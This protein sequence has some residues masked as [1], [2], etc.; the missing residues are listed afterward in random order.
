MLIMPSL[1]LAAYLYSPAASG[2]SLWSLG[3]NPAHRVA[4]IHQLLALP[5]IWSCQILQYK[6]YPWIWKNPILSKW[7]T[8][9]SHRYGLCSTPRPPF[10]NNIGLDMYATWLL[11]SLSFS[12]SKCKAGPSFFLIPN[13][14]PFL[15]FLVAGIAFCLVLFQ[16]WRTLGFRN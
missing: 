4:F 6:Q 2:M 13:R 5:L 11:S 3:V 16:L 15:A 7:P 10:G 12:K 9:G 8:I 14:A 1:L